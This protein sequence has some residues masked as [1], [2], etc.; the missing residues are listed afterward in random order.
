VTKPRIR[1]PRTNAKIRAHFW[2]LAHNAGCPHAKIAFAVEADEARP[3]YWRAMDSAAKNRSAAAK[4][5]A[6][7]TIPFISSGDT[8][9]NEPL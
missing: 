7:Y 9:N 6:S 5:V 2:Q 1:P 8:S 3:D 4:L